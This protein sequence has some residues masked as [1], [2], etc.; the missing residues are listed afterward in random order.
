MALPDCV[1]ILVF[2]FCHISTATN[3]V[4]TTSTFLYFN[5]AFICWLVRGFHNLSAAS[6]LSAHTAA[7]TCINARRADTRVNGRQT[8]LSICHRPLVGRCA[9]SGWRALGQSPAGGGGVCCCRYTLHLRFFPTTPYSHHQWFMS[10]S[11]SAVYPGQY[12]SRH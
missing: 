2:S 9:G 8:M 11:I 3:H 12:F 4:L 5:E 1:D 10:A 7:D 6:F